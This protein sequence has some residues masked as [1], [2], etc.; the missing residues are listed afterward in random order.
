MADFK[1]ITGLNGMYSEDLSKRSIT[2]MRDSEHDD[3][4]GFISIVFGYE[5]KLT[6]GSFI[7]TLQTKDCN[8]IFSPDKIR[9][10]HA[11]FLDEKVLKACE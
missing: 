6:H 8:W 10:K 2:H 3:H 7:E 5:A 9:Q 1:K 11:K 4:Q